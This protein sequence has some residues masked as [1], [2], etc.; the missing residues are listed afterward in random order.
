MFA[1]VFALSL[2]R[3]S[4][5]LPALLLFACQSEP[6][7]ELVRIEL[8]ELVTSTDPVRPTVQAR[9]AGRSRTLTEGFVLEVAPPDVATPAKD[10]TLTCA[11]SGDAH[12]TA[13]VRGVRGTT[14]LKCRLVEK[15]ELGELPPFDA[16]GAPIPLVVRV[17]AR[18]GKELSDVPVTVSSENP[19]LLQVSG[20]TLKPLA[21]GETS[22]TV[23]AGSKELKR[24]VRIARTLDP[25]ALPIDGG[26]RIHF[27][28]PEG[29]FEVEVTLAVEKP[30]HIEWRGAP[31]CGYRATA[32]THRS[33]C[34]LQGKGGVVIDNPAFLSSGSTD[35]SKQGVSLREIR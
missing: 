24:N 14:S 34:T 31:Y 9:S 5:L 30:M 12:V 26:R 16:G 18:G 22:F 23:R 19:R 3:C 2:R 28:L 17:L 8:P 29:K 7:P 27:S 15:L 25:E 11:K 20:T 32:K 4:R 21:V 33:S 1:A 35:V 10:G 6:P 13:N